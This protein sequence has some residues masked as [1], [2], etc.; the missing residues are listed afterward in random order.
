MEEVIHYEFMPSAHSK[1][2]ITSER[3][4]FIENTFLQI[5]L[6]MSS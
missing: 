6:F 5:F 1:T 4:V 2:A 3:S